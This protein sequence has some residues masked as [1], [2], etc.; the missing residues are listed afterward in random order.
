MKD[1]KPAVNKPKNR[2]TK[3]RKVTDIIKSEEAL[4]LTLA[5]HIADCD[6]AITDVQKDSREVFLRALGA[7]RQGMLV[8]DSLDMEDLEK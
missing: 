2:A 1:S 5:L 4:L 7:Y 8:Y 3:S 6:I